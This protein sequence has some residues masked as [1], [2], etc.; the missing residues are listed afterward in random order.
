LCRLGVVAA[1][2]GRVAGEHQRQRVRCVPVEGALDQ[3]FHALAEMPVVGQQQGLG[4]A[5]E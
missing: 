5:R 3:V 1:R 2:Q 4:L